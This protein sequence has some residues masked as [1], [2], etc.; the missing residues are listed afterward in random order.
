MNRTLPIPIVVSSA[1]KCGLALTY[2]VANNGKIEQTSNPDFTTDAGRVQL[3]RLMMERVG[4]TGFHFYLFER[5]GRKW[6]SDTIPIDYI[7]TDGPLVE[8]V[9]EWLRNKTSD[10]LTT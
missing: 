1:K 2:T 4:W 7:L 6:V 8:A 3:L 10:S 9:L 5:L